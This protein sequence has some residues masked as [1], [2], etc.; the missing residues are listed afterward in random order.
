[1]KD[2]QINSE[3]LPS[4]EAIC[5][6]TDSIVAPVREGTVDVL[7]ANLTIAAV[8]EALQ[9]AAQEIKGNVIDELHKYSAKEKIIVNGN[10][11]QLKEVGTK[12]DY[13]SAVG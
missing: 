11:Y 3:W 12:Y 4:E 13:S 10:A 6:L 2:L 1:M 8:S 9:R 5:K 7:K